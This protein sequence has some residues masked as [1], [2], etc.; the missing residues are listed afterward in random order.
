M[1]SSSS[2]T[3]I[4]GGL[5]KTDDPCCHGS[6]ELMRQLLPNSPIIVTMPTS[7]V[8]P[9]LAIGDQDLSV[10]T[11]SRP[12]LAAHRLPRSID[13]QLTGDVP[14]THDHRRLVAVLAA[15]VLASSRII[16]RT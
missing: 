7:R 6:P 14:V 1:A 2:T 13:P 16:G 5:G 10:G 9:P 3:A 12:R 4:T 8:Q 15:D 11:I